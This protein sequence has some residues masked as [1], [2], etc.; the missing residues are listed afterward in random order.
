M[1]PLPAECG[2]RAGYDRL[3]VSCDGVGEPPFMWCHMEGSVP[4]NMKRSSSS[5]FSRVSI[6]RSDLGFCGIAGGDHRQGL[7][8]STSFLLPEIR[9]SD[10][11]IF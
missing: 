6:Y 7:L 2:R 1:C 8:L 11:K 9:L 10:L 3:R 5:F 4:V